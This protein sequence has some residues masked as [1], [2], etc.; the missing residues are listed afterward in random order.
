MQPTRTL[1]GLVLAAWFGPVAAAAEPAMESRT[2]FGADSARRW[3]AAES[4]IESSTTR[5]RAGQPVLHWHVT[6]DHFAGEAKYPIGWP[7]ISLDLK[8]PAERDWSG[9][10]YLQM[11][12]YTDTTR[13][14]LPRDPA[15]LSLHNPDRQGAFGLPLD[16]LRKGQWVQI[17]I[18]LADVPRHNDV[19]L[20]QFHISESSYKHQDQL[21]F[22]F[23]D[24]ALLRYAGP[25]PLDFAPE[26]AVIFAD[27]RQLAVQFNLAGVKPDQTVEMACELRQAEKV[28]AR[29]VVQAIRGPQRV[30]LDLGPA[31]LR[32][33]EYEVSVRPAG[34]AEAATARV[35]LVES[36]WQPRE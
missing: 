5:T 23:D 9:W 27:A 16:Q 31:G 20:I 3:S 36:P 1:L 19:R 32:P 2:L 18:P 6:V 30:S 8:T 14:R 17:R 12:V 4:T 35:R 26:S 7:R 25:T 21:D 34:A 22:Y 15:G 24:V 29:A 28:V 33:G 13:E 10:D 11:W